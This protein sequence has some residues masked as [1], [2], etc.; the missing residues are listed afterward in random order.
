MIWIKEGEAAGFHSAGPEEVAMTAKDTFGYLG[1]EELGARQMVR[2]FVEMLEK[3]VA[4]ETGEAVEQVRTQARALLIRARRL[5][6]EAVDSPERLRE[7]VRQHPFVALG[8]AGLAGFVLASMRR[9]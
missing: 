3:L 8:V 5:I 2:A 7:V 1:N 4:S 9:R 6:D